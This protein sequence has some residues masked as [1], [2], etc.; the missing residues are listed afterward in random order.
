MSAYSI[1]PTTQ[2]GKKNCMKVLQGIMIR[3]I[4]ME[5]E[6]EPEDPGRPNDFTR[7][8]VLA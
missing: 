3:D 7:P 6:E 2:S 4:V 1:L 8:L 5:R